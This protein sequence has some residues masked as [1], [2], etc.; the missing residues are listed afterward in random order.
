MLLAAALLLV[1][2]AGAAPKKT[3]APH[4]YQMSLESFPEA[5][6]EAG[7]LVLKPSP[8]K[9]F[10]ERIFGIGVEVEGGRWV[11]NDGEFQLEVPRGSKA[12]IGFFGMAGWINAEKPRK[13]G[14]QNTLPLWVLDGKRRTELY[15]PLPGEEGYQPVIIISPSE[16]QW[17]KDRDEAVKAALQKKKGK[18]SPAS[19]KG[20]KK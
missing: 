10:G 14:G 15:V 20:E 9:K 17:E 12:K 8:D 5:R 1:P 16:S 6:I 19:K 4:L 11:E 7:F 18:S 2:H 3:P 13:V